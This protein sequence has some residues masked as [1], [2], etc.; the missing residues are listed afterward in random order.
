MRT[1]N[2]YQAALAAG[3]SERMARS[4]SYISHAE[5]ERLGELKAIVV[6]VGNRPS[7]SSQPTAKSNLYS[8]VPSE[9]RAKARQL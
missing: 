7:R 2:A 6:P 8:Q 9:R 4:K 1:G 5:P 3:Y